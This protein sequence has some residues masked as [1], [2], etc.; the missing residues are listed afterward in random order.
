MKG[1][2]RMS[3]LTAMG[4]RGGLITKPIAAVS[5]LAIAAC[6]GL[7]VAG[8]LNPPAGPVVPTMKTLAEIEP[9]IAINE[10]NTPGD[11]GSLYRITMP[12]SYYLTGNVTVS[13]KTAIKIMASNVTVDLNGFSLIGSGG[14]SIGVRFEDQAGSYACT[15]LRNGCVRG[16]SFDGVNLYSNNARGTLVENI[17][18]THNGGEGISVSGGCALRDCVASNN[19]GVGLFLSAYQSS[20]IEDCVANN[21]GSTGIEVSGSASV[22]RACSA[23]QNGGDGIVAGRSAIAE[24]SVA[25]NSGCGIRATLGGSVTGCTTFGNTADGIQ[26]DDGCRVVGNNC[27]ADGGFTSA[28]I[29]VTGLGNRIEGNNCTDAKRGIDV[30]VSGNIIIRNTCSGNDVNWDIVAGNKCLV[31]TGANAGP[32]LGNSGGVSLGSTDPNA[33]FTY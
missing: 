4:L 18:A 33:N 22:V 32:I 24:C 23:L 11:A 13:G 16:M 20:A 9:R 3:G 30:D 14:G 12:G 31:V 29:H 6:A 28:A 7:L 8:P 26:V 10:T 27:R 2:R 21:N 19:G 1:T 25:A 17:I 15:T 5:A